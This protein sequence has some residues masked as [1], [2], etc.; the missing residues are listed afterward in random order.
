MAR[1][2]VLVPRAKYQQML[3]EQ[4]NSDNSPVHD[5][6]KEDERTESKSLFNIDIH[7]LP[8]SLHRRANALIRF[9]LDHG[10]YRLSWNDKGEIVLEGTVVKNSCMNDLLKY[11]LTSKTKRLPEG[12]DLFLKT[13]KSIDT[14]AA[15]VRNEDYT[16]P[17][18][19][20]GEG[21][22]VRAPMGPPPG[23]RPSKQ[24]PLPSQPKKSRLQ[25]IQF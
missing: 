5:R 7:N 20:R 2:L 3:K 8:K 22:V 6:E 15:L 19:Q 16:E 9:I 17:Q 25:W 10:G 14:P 18:D 13:L 24:K 11:A 1:D 4:Q 21:Y 23:F 12:H